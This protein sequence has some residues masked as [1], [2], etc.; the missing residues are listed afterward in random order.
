MGIGGRKKH[1]MVKGDGG[2][3]AG[4]RVVFSSL[5]AT[6]KKKKEQKTLRLEDVSFVLVLP[7]FCLYYNISSHLIQSYFLLWPRLSFRHM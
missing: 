2:C 1:R 5:K 4:F 6:L 7:L 3:L